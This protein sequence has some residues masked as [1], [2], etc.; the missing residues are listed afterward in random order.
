[1]TVFRDFRR[2]AD[3]L[4][5]LAASVTAAASR[6]QTATAL[7]ERIEDLERERS[8]WEAEVEGLLAKAEGKLKAAANSE[9]RERT[10]QKRFADDADPFL[11]PGE[12]I[13]AT[14]PAGDVEVGGT[15]EVLP[16]RLDVA[17]ESW[18]TRALMAKFSQ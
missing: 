4:E 17:S 8:L 14:V 11:A 10:M 6:Q 1:M 9:A 7:T 12:E 3:S 13:E 18:K 15:E 2:I 5:R 16:L